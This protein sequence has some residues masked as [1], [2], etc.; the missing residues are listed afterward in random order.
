LNFPA[1]RFEFEN[2]GAYAQYNW[3]I[4]FHAP[5]L[6][7][8]RLSTNQK[9]QEAQHWFH[10]IFN[11]TDASANAAPA[12]FWRTLPFA[13]TFAADYSG[14]AIDQLMSMLNAEADTPELQDTEKA[15]QRWQRDAFN[16]HLVART[17]TTA[18]QKTV[19]MKYIDNLV[20][21]GDSLF[22]RETR[23][24]VS[25]ATQLYLLAA[26]LLGPRPRRIPRLT[27]RDEKS[28]RQLNE[29]GLDAFSN[30]LVDYENYLPAS[31]PA[32]PVGAI[33]VSSYVAELYGQLDRAVLAPVNLARRSLLHSPSLQDAAKTQTGGKSLYFCVPP[34]S[35]FLEYWDRVADRL[36]KIRHCQNID[37]QAMQLSLLSPSIDPAILVRAKAMGVDFNTVLGDL[38]APLPH[39]RFQVLAQK[40]T[41]LCGEVKSL[42]AALLSALEKSDGEALALLRNTQ[43]N[44]LLEA[45]Q[46]IKE[47]QIVEA[48]RGLEGLQK[49]HEATTL[50]RDHNQ[51]LLME[52]VSPEEVA[53]LGLS[54]ASMLLQFAQIGAKSGSAA[55]SLVPNIK[56]GFVTTLG[57]MFGGHQIGDA[58]ER[59]SDVFGHLAGILSSV[60][61]MVSTMGGYRRRAEDWGLQVALASKELEGLEKQIAAA[62]IRVAVAES[63][64]ENHKLQI[65]H[66]KETKDFMQKKY[67]SQELYDWMV[68][69]ISTLY[70]QT[71]QLAYDLAKKCER[72]FAH[73]LGVDSPGL[74]RPGYWDNLKKGLLA[75]EQLNQDIKR[76]EVAYLNQNK[77]EFELT[78]HI[79]LAL[80]DPTA[81]VILRETGRCIFNLPEEIFDLDY[82]GHYFRRIKSVS[83]TLPCVAGPYTTISCTLRLVK[84]SFRRNVDNPSNYRLTDASGLPVPDDRFSESAISVKAI[85][86]SSAQND[87]GVFE[88]GF[89]DERYLPFE[90]AGVISTWSLELFTDPANKEFGKS[91]RQF[92]YSTISDA[93]LHLKYTAREDVGALKNAAIGNLRKYF[94][95]PGVK[96]YSDQEC[97]SPS[98]LMLDLRRDFASQWSRFINPTDVSNGNVFELETSSALFPVRDAAKTLKINEIFLLA[99]CTQQG[100]YK[101]TLSPPLPVPPF[102]VPPSTAN[103]FTLAI[104]NKYGLHKGGIASAGVTVVPTNP[105]VTWKIALASPT[106]GNLTKDPAEVM[107]AILLLGYEWAD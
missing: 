61:G 85:A 28:F 88:L 101:V 74:I 53:S 57:A 97:L 70:F 83:L 20:A 100:Q 95:Q 98:L 4:F 55:G 43:E 54:A 23:E 93:I 77:R 38:Y 81:L 52:F 103:T 16:P 49:S 18:F 27:R 34:N 68:S 30:A 60:G 1:E 86:A 66:S 82:P 76:L 2:E 44:R 71:Y 9:F 12:K 29:S 102:S 25:E 35:D 33:A 50:R 11:P 48:S 65:R 56:G 67:T 75:G 62:E 42:G 63:D 45:V 39:Y 99:R 37:G 73:E 79:S 91:L 105:P 13:N 84:N 8:T 15:V 41:E 59:V 14:Q 36:F 3:E 69:Q 47:Y 26:K 92:D 40:A 87:S 58:G 19:V 89:R 51:R 22:R 7:A 21:W 24:A 64:L 104:D 80:L 107:D 32:L 78:K 5:L 6:I 17:R 94:T 46:T 90:G 31:G 106:G 72:S 10:Y 96:K